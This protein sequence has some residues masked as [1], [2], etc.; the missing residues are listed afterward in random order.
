MA[1]I[2]LTIEADSADDLAD[3]LASLVG[4]FDDEGAAPV[5]AVE[6]TPARRGRPRNKPAAAAPDT[7]AS[8]APETT[9]PVAG[10]EAGQTATPAA[11]DGGPTKATIL[12]LMSDAMEAASALGVT[13]AL[14]AAGLPCR[15]SEIPPE[16]YG[17]V[18]AVLEKLIALS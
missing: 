18:A 3:A 7:N 9:A 2:V 6:P 14:D 10:A 12:K 4:A 17:E 16:K 1:K 5:A 15:A 8:G 11:G 13:Q